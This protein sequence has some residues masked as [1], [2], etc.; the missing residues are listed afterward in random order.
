MRYLGA[1]VSHPGRD[2]VVL[3][4]MSDAPEPGPHDHVA[5]AAIART[6]VFR[7]RKP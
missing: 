4:C 6:P 2:P 1:M 3:T 5:A 7:R